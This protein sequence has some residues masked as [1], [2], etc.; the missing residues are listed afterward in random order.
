[1][2][3]PSF[4]SAVTVFA[5]GCAVLSSSACTKP[6]E[7]ASRSSSGGAPPAAQ[8]PAAPA[9]SAPVRVAPSQA[10]KWSD[11]QRWT[12]RP[13]ASGMRVAEY[14]VPGAGGGDGECTVVTFGE[15]Q[16]GSL[17]AN[18][19]RWV[20]Q[21]GPIA[22]PPTRTTHMVQGIP[23][24]RI[25]LVGTYHPMTMPGMPESAPQSGT[26]MIGAIAQVPTGDWFFKMTGPDATVKAAGPDFDTMIDSIHTP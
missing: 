22:A 14:V 16:G 26:R 20:K 23:V 18:V 1:M 15:H 17:E 7:P 8:S 13:P 6:E 4:R 12:R 25:E 5:V 2:P 9:P 21:F 10:L 19:S 24:T 11:P 3:S